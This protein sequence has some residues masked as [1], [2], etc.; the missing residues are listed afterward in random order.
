MRLFWTGVLL[1][2]LLLIGLSTYESGT[3]A[4]GPE[5]SMSTMEDGT[6]MPEPDPTPTPPP[7]R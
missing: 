4:G 7:Q 6:P 5:P 1:T 2:G 3:A